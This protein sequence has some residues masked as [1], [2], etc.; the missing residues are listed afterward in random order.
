MLRLQDDDVQRGYGAWPT[1]S[2]DPIAQ[3]ST[4]SA[5]TMGPTSPTTM[6]PI[7]STGFIS[8]DSDEASDDEGKD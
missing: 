7:A 6:S 3:V 2:Y 8:K 4:A 5:A 1:F